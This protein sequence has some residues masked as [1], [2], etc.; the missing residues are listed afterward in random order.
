MSTW[1][2]MS[3]STGAAFRAGARARGAPFV[4]QP[5]GLSQIP[6]GEAA[7]DPPR[8][9]AEPADIE[10]PPVEHAAS[11]FTVMTSWQTVARMAVPRGRPVDNYSPFIPAPGPD[12]DDDLARRLLV[13]QERPE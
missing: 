6:S 4:D 3:R 7:R 13:R 8:E 11:S 1:T 2:R 12:G 10:D 9:A 5:P